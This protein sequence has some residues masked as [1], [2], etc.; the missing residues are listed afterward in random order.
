MMQLAFY[1]GPP[2]GLM[3]KVGHWGTKVFT[4]SQYS[5]CELVINGTCCSSSSR[6]GGVRFK[7]IDLT[8]GKWDVYEV[9]GDVAAAWDW[10]CIHAGA[11]Y[12]WAGI[13]RFLLPF[14][15][16][17]SNQWFCSEA[18]AAALGLPVPE[19]YS[20]QTLFERMAIKYSGRE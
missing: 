4:G 8:T 12:D 6:D 9:D 2:T 14:L 17:H 1:K 11:K 13:W 15:P 19:N 5:H 3:H 18:C 10:F 20:P 16:Q 7:T